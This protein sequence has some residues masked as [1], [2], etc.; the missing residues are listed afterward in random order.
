M[1]TREQIE[2]QAAIGV[3]DEHQRRGQLRRVDERD[4][5]V[6]VL[7]HAMRLRHIS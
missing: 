4:H 1:C 7:L 6:D 5:V 2:H 3:G